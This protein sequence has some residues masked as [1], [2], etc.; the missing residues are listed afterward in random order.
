MVKGQKGVS[1]CAATK[2]NLNQIEKFA[3]ASD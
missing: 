2:I 3:V 1:R